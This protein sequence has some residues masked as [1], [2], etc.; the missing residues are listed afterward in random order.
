MCTLHMHSNADCQF[1]VRLAILK[2][3]L[4]IQFPH[5]FV[6]LEMDPQICSAQWD[7]F[8][9]GCM[10]YCVDFHKQKSWNFASYVQ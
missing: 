3:L 6:Q 4:L 2:Q 5:Q 8:I 1:I 7:S 10:W 9:I